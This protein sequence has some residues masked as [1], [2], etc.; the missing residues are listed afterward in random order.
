M[1]V[2]KTHLDLFVL[3]ELLLYKRSGLPGSC[4]GVCPA[5]RLSEGTK[6]ADKK[7]ENTGHDWEHLHTLAALHPPRKSV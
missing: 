2:W 5:G 7:M 3:E 4:G 1:C 6:R